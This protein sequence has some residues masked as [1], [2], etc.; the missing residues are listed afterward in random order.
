MSRQVKW[1]FVLREQSPLTFE[2]AQQAVQQ[3][4]DEHQNTTTDW[5]YADLLNARTGGVT[6]I[7]STQAAAGLGL[8]TA[9]Y[10]LNAQTATVSAQA[11]AVESLQP[12]ATE[13]T[14]TAVSPGYHGLNREQPGTLQDQAHIAAS[15]RDILT[16]PLGSRVMRREY[17]SGVMDLLGKPLNRSGVLRVKNAIATALMRWEPRIKLHRVQ[18][19]VQPAGRATVHLTGQ[20]QNQSQQLRIAL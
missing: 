6:R 20:I 9:I 15:I 14:D 10:P 1:E 7:Y 5:L 8:S 13:T 16:T 17:G 11:P 4:L 19:D 12:A 3:A 18:L 2:Q